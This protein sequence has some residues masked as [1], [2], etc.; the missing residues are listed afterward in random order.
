MPAKINADECTGCG[1]CAEACP[2][3]AITVEEVAKVNEAECTECGNCVDECP[4]EA[5]TLD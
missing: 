5:I 3:E 1:L 4:A 2:V